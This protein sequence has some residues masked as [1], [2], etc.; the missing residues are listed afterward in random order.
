MILSEYC[1]LLSEIKARIRAAQYS[2][3]KAVNKEH[4]ALYWDIGR[5]IVE[6]QSQGGW[7]KSVVE[8]LAR[9]LQLEFPGIQGFSAANLWRM[10]GFFQTYHRLEKLA[11]LVREI[12]W[13][14]NLIIMEKCK[15]DL[16][17]EF[18]I[19]MTR[20][21]GWTKAVLIHQ[22]ENRTYEKTLLKRSRTNRSVS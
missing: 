9:V 20:K 10:R 21:F 11:P 6:R 13:S 5:M 14:H 18:Y 22:I 8:Q 12:G 17:R 19:R 1:A 7:G 2:A 3:L 15:D 16:E 4:I